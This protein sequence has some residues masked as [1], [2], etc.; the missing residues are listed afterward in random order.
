MYYLRQNGRII[1][2]SSNQKFARLKK[3]Y[4]SALYSYFRVMNLGPSY[5]A[6]RKGERKFP[7]FRYS[8]TINET[9]IMRRLRALKRDLKT[10]DPQDKVSK[11]FLEWRIAETQALYHFWRARK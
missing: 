9:T 1:T 3:T 4:P 11:A 8:K 5:R 7:V 2:V 10:I 6:F